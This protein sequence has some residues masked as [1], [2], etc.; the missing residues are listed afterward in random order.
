MV[1]TYELVGSFWLS[2]LQ[3]LDID[4]GLNRDDGLAIFNREHQEANMPHL[5]SEW[6]TYHN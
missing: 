6:P 2:Q 4:I 3:D 5:Q 1:Q